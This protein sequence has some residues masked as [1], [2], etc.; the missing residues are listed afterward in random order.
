ML[1]R[2][3]RRTIRREPVVHRDHALVGYHVAGHSAADEHRVQPLVVAQPVNDGLPRRIPPQHVE[4][5]AGQVDRVR[6]HPG[7][8]GVRPPARHGHGGAQRALAAALD[9][10]GRRLEQDREVPGERRRVDPCQPRQPAA[11]GLDLFAVV[12]HVGHVVHGRRHRGGEPQLHRDTRLHVGRPAPVQPV[13]AHRRRQV[14]RDRHRVD[15]PGQHH[16]PRT[17]QRGA[18]DQRVPVP[19]YRQPRQTAKAILDGAGQHVFRAADRRNVHQRGGQRCPGRGKVKV[20]PGSLRP[21]ARTACPWPPRAAPGRSPPPKAGARSPF[22][23]PRGR[24]GRG[25]ARAAAAARPPAGRR[26]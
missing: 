20:H 9:L 12:E 2:L 5:A 1:R 11:R 22:A 3:G 8:R 17:P 16:P 19:E 13:P 15:V 23:P 14:V 21:I 24:H 6:A 26:R 10:P 4:H 18:C 7:P 25:R